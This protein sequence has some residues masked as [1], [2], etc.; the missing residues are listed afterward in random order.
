[1]ADLSFTGDIDLSPALGSVDDFSSLASSSLDQALQASVDSFVASLGSALG[2]I[3]DA[4]VAVTADVS[5]AETE[6]SSLV[7]NVD[8]E[9]ASITVDADTSQAEEASAGLGDSLDST[10]ASASRSKGSLKE[11]GDTAALIGG[12]AALAT[13]E[14]GGAGDVIAGTGLASVGAVAGVA[15]LGGSVFELAQKGIYAT[16]AEERFNAILGDT[17]AAVETIH[18][19]SLDEDVYKLGISFGST[20]AAMQ[21]SLS[22]I[23]QFAVN[24]GAGRDEAA[25]FS[26]EIVALSARAISLNPSLGSLGDVADSLSVRLARGGRFAASYG[27]SLTA[28]DINARALAN[29]HKDAA[30]DLTVYE[31]AE[32]AAQ[33]ATEKYGNSLGTIVA[34]GAKNAAN[35][36]KSLT[37][38]LDQLLETAGKPLVAPIFAAIKDALP[39]VIAIA[40]PLAQIGVGVLPAIAG[41]ASIAAPP[42]RAVASAIH[43]IPGPVLAIAAGSILLAGVLD[44]VITRF[45]ATGAAA[46]EMAVGE[47]TAGA[48]TAGLNASLGLASITAGSAALGVGALVAGVVIGKAIFEAINAPM[49]DLNAQLKE[50]ADL[51]SQVAKA[52]VTE[53]VPSFNKLADTVLANRNLSYVVGETSTSYSKLEAQLDAFRQVAEKDVTQAELLA[54]STNHNSAEYRGMLGVLAAVNAQK[55]QQAIVTH[56]AAEALANETTT[57]TPATQA[58]NDYNTSTATAT[59]NTTDFKTALHDLLGVQGDVTAAMVGQGDA[60]A[61]LNAAVEKNGTTFDVNTQAGRDNLKALQA[62]AGAAETLADALVKQ[63]GKASDGQAA[64]SNFTRELEG[65]LTSLGL[66]KTAV[67][68]LVSSIGLI[69]SDK[70]VTVTADTSQAEGA[71]SSFFSKV[72]G[73]GFFNDVIGANAN[74]EVFLPPRAAGGPV[75]AG[76]AYLVGEQGAEM[77]VPQTAGTIVPNGQLFRPSTWDAAPATGA[78]SIDNSITITGLDASNRPDPVDVAITTARRVR[79]QQVLGA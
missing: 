76:Q 53:L 30:G 2:G 77:F 52:N 45:V 21:N 29:T 42:L 58:L 49:V 3:S 38:Q 28:A 5:P 10:G 57:I 35:E 1:M 59:G 44:K 64:M 67:D 12:S 61:N 40:S 27:V 32:A 48:A 33:L 24:S 79:V 16:A 19:G 51:T 14:I 47:E 60:S 6:V 75:Q 73:A 37:A 31:K 34:Q 22:T 11:W 4:S 55:A 20:D 72:T 18:V 25:Q 15:A 13:G 71:L 65:T 56:N 36:Q 63:S 54:A 9:Q 17:A 68:N 50:E 41:A 46:G 39:D 78:Q 8:S 62:D 70:A 26:Q 74:S 66:D 7:A 43:D 69:P 23:F